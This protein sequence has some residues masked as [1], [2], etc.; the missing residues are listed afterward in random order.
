MNTR[1][2]IGLVSLNRNGSLLVQRGLAMAELRNENSRRL[3]DYLRREPRRQAFC[4]TVE[5]A[6]SRNR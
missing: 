5:I 6:R 4:G 3:G 2:C 1:R